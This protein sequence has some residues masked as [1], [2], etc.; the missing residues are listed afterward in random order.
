MNEIMVG[1]CITR[2]KELDSD[3]IDSVVTD[4]P[5]ELGFMGKHWDNSGIA[6]SLDLWQEVYR[7]LKPGGYLLS[8]GGTRTYHRMA[9]AIED[10]GFEIRDMVEWLYGSGF[11]KGL[12]IGKAVD[13]LQGN[14]RNI[15]INNPHYCEGRKIDPELNTVGSKLP[16][17]PKI[18]YKGT[19][20]YEG[21]GTALKPAHEPICMARKPL[22]EKSVAQNVLK[23]GT[24]GINIDGCRVEAKDNW[25]SRHNTEIKEWKGGKSFT[26][27]EQILSSNPQGRFPA[28][29][30]HDGSDEVV[31]IFPNARSSNTPSHTN[32]KYR[33]GNTSIFHG[34]S[35][36]YF[37]DSGSAA[38]FFYCAKA[39]KEDLNDK[40]KWLK[41]GVGT[42]IS[43]RETIIA[44]NNHPTVKPLALMKYLIKLVTPPNG[45]VL[46]PFTGSGSTLVAAKQLGY[47][48]IG[49]EKEKE[50]VK[51][52]EARLSAVKTQLSLE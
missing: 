35:S 33:A 20:P 49:I 34:Q 3:S 46:D 40:K 18:I 6:Y 25:G 32:K 7:V 17:Q 28:N 41:G 48:F 15:P 27:P 9:C 36:T 10:A 52:A 2:L 47:N 29:L 39:S 26:H 31:K 30:I 22:S 14:N 5:Y 38:R 37:N 12:N 23:H 16:A 44:K 50:Y 1:D 4:P 43:A 45:T 51:I 24:G 8:F 11:P 42:G 19:S 21:Y 13:K